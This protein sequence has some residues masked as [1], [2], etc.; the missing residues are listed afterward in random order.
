MEPAT[1]IW[2][3]VIWTSS[4]IENGPLRS[5]S[6]FNPVSI[7]GSAVR[8]PPWFAIFCVS[9]FTQKLIP[10]SPD[11]CIFKS[12]SI[13]VWSTFLPSFT[14]ITSWIPGERYSIPLLSPERYSQS[15]SSSIE[16]TNSSPLSEYLDVSSLFSSKWY[17]WSSCFTNWWSIICMTPCAS[18]NGIYSGTI[19]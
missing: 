10:H 8:L 1:I 6:L 15:L 18:L 5:S 19:V 2:S 11:G 16:E 3:F 4:I 17:T 13:V 7:H 9:L 14:P 12:P